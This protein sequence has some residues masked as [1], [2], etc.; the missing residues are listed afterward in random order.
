M[1]VLR[2]E[3]PCHTEKEYVELT[4]L[5]ELAE[6]LTITQKISV[7][8]EHKSLCLGLDIIVVIFFYGIST[9]VI[10]YNL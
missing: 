10:I 4:E 5:T 3:L 8:T 6:E 1:T 7:A 9:I 2:N